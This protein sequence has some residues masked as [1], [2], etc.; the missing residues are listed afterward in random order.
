MS[1][2]FEEFGKIARF[3]REC[4]VTEK[5]DGT[6]AQVAIFELEGRPDEEALV[7]VNGCALYAGSRTRWVTRSDDNF[8]FAQ[9]AYAHAEELID[10]LGPG[11]HYGEWWGA[12]IQ[13]GYGLQEKRFSLFNTKRWTPETTP[14]ICSV[15]PVLWSGLLEHFNAD[16]QILELTE[17]G[18]V[19]APGF[20]K[21]EGFVLYHVASGNYYKK[22]VLKDEEWKGKSA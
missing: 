4:V 20:M 21:A 17:R 7:S 1:R 8:G 13:R 19:A 18:S 22:T 3:N 14:S 5:I 12:G 16:E 15:V 2:E 6:N 10:G 9:W 11:K